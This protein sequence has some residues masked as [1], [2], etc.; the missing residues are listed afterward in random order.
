MAEEV[1]IAVKK[2]DW[3]RLT[4]R[5]HWL[6]CLESAGVDNWEGIDHAKEEFRERWPEPDE[7]EEDD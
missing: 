4:R 2:R 6:F 5:N 3:D 1:M 7:E